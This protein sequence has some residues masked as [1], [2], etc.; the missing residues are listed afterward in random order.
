VAPIVGSILAPW[1]SH[2]LVDGT[3]A[4]MRAPDYLLD[5]QTTAIIVTTADLSILYLNQ[6]A[7]AL[8]EVSGHRLVGESLPRVFYDETT[9]AATLREVA[10][11]G[12]AFTKRGA[13]A[14][15]IGGSTVVVDYTISAMLDRVPTELLIEIQP[16]DRLL[17]INRDDHHVSVQETTRK[18]IRGLA[19]EI[20]NPLGG[21]RGAAQL[22]QRELQSEHQRDY[23]RIIIEEADRLRN[24]VDRMLGPSQRPVLVGVNV[25]HA[26]ER[27][28][29]L[30]EA[31]APGRIKVVRDYDPSLPEVQADLE[32]LIQALLNILRNA[33]QALEKTSAPTIELRTRIIRQ[34]TIGTVRHRLVLRID[35][36]DNGPGIPAELFDR[37]YYPMISGRADGSGLG[38]SI[39]QSI[40]AHHH[41]LIECE[42]QPGATTFSI[43]LPLEQPHGK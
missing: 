21:I 16:L 22:L 11:G 39:A 42:S 28:V 38:L 25:H 33:H 19:H 3:L 36:S 23:T 9:P 43:Y 18:L 32:Q 17:R 1:W 27:V 30:L 8:L 31:E 34:F 29:A 2:A 13:S 10:H 4:R 40:V 5:Q 35:I 24:L 26:L 6:A 20:K 37:M 15:T 7:E 14:R 41:G 12:Q